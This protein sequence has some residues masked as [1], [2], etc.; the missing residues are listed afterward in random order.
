ME[1]LGR[2]FWLAVIYEGALVLVLAALM[3][4]KLLDATLFIAWLAAFGTGFVTYVMGNVADK[5]P[6][7][8]VPPTP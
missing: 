4:L 3:L 7:P 6:V 8:P 2:K 1:K 5:G